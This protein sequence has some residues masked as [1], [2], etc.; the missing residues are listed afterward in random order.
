MKSP[1]LSRVGCEFANDI[2][3]QMN[4]LCLS[5]LH[6]YLI[7]RFVFSIHLFFN[8]KKVHEKVHPYRLLTEFPN[9]YCKVKVYTNGKK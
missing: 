3:T 4:S 6:K 9:I 8:I 5:T 2:K 1:F 7:D